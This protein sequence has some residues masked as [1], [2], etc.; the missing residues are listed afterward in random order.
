MNISFELSGKILTAFIFGELDECSAGAAK[1][2]LDE[3]ISKRGFNGFIFNLSGLTFMDS[4]GI[5][6]LLGRY[7]KLLAQNAAV[8]IDPP[9]PAIDKVLRTSGIYNVIKKL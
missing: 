5:G 6:V 7:K 9:P 8:Y 2:A 1:A 4:T 3:A